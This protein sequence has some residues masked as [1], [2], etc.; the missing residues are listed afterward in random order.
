MMNK[1][2]LFLSIYFNSCHQTSIIIESCLK[3]D[4]NRLNIEINVNDTNQS[5]GYYMNKDEF[6]EYIIFIERPVLN[7][8]DKLYRRE[9]DGNHSLIEID[10]RSNSS[11]K[12]KFLSNDLIEKFKNE[13][14]T[15]QLL[16]DDLKRRRNNALKIKGLNENYEPILKNNSL[17]INSSLIPVLYVKYND[18]L[19]FKSFFND[20]LLSTYNFY[21]LFPHFKNEKF[22]QVNQSVA[23]LCVDE[24]NSSLFDFNISFYEIICKDTK[25]IFNEKSINKE[26]LFNILFVSLNN[27]T[28]YSSLR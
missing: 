28:I 24:S 11:K 21:I 19:K 20:T 22:Y 9:D 7:N 12:V 1:I 16:N 25:F 17:I 4:S 27:Q 15:C 14:I 8:I 3:N 2:F 18:P 26:F 10:E 6:I 5:I 13:N 23:N